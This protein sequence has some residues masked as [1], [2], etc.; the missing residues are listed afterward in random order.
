MHDTDWTALAE[1]I[2]KNH[3]PHAGH[4][5]WESDRAMAEI[6]VLD[7]FANAL[8]HQGALFFYGARHRGEGEGPP[9]CYAHAGDGAR[10]GIEITAL[11]DGASIAAARLGK[12][13]D[14]KGWKGLL[15][16]AL[17]KLLSRKDKSRSIQGGPY[18]QYVLVIF[19]DKPWL[20]RD[21]L[22]YTIENHMFGVTHLITKTFLLL[23]YDPFIQRYP[24]YELRLSPQKAAPADALKHATE[25]YR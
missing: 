11:V 25:L 5:S 19:S 3:R 17:E 18:S 4:F 14:W 23:S 10:I 20:E 13:Y 16:P 12:P 21:Y 22:E 8:A 9:D 1:E 7:E 2:K 15:L 24:C 6:G